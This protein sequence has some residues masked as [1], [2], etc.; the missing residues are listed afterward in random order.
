MGASKLKVNNSFEGL[1]LSVDCLI[2]NNREAT[3][4]G[5]HLRK[6]PVSFRP[7][8]L[9]NLSPLSRILVVVIALR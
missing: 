9:N 1:K 4:P 6:H 2:R 3:L 8:G 5:R 7:S